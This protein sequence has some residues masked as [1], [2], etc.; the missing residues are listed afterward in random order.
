MV[1]E[2]RPEE[3][4]EEEDQYETEADLTAEELEELKQT[5][6]GKRAE[7]I[8]L[9]EKHV[10]EAVG[11]SVNLPDEMDLA[12]QQS[13]RGFLL[14]MADKK[15][16]LLAEIDRA[17]RKFALGEYGIC[18]GTG[19]P[20]GIRRLRIRPWTRWSIEHKEELE[21]QKRAGKR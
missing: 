15:K 14:R 7:V 20:I 17:L 8:V 10:R 13:E 21:K 2:Q 1:T 4:F 18:E 11:D 16:K 9:L 3:D 19:E 6:L 12:S 5:L